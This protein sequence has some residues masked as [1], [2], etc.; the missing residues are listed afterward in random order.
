[1]NYSK[2]ISSPIGSLYLIANDHAL[3]HLDTI[4][5][6]I[7][8]NAISA[9]NHEILNLTQLQLD[10]Y[11]KGLRTSFNL[12]IET[13]GTSF[14]K[15]VWSALLEIPFGMLWTYKQQANFLKKPKA[16]RAVGAANGK[17]PIPIIIPCH[18][19]IGSNGAPIGY[20]KGLKIKLDLIAHEARKISTT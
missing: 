15:E 4:E 18:R 1:M 9:L 11:F 14:Q 16:S 6:D 13:N 19:V 17:N 7:Y 20:S 3:I 5:N 10:E 12:P 2:K 8:K